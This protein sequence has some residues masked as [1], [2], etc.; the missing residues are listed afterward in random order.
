[1]SRHR[2][3]PRA[4]RGDL[5][6]AGFGAALAGGLLLAVR[7]GWAGALLLGGLAALFLGFVLRTLARARQVVELTP[8][9][10]S[11]SGPGLHRTLPWDGIRHLGLRYFATRRD[12]SGGWLVLTLGG[13][14][15]TIRIESQIDGFDAILAR[16]AAAARAN[17]ATMSD[18]TAGNLSAL[19][20]LPPGPATGATS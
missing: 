20:I 3:P 4:L 18:D 1:M 8:D 17:G 10:L 19:G 9:A 16:A 7:P 12:R 2:Y 15:T 14:G 13:A 11:L 5:I 6:G